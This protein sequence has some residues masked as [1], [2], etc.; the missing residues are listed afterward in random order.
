MSIV[1]QIY[2]T[3]RVIQIIIGSLLGLHS[4]NVSLVRHDSDHEGELWVRSFWLIHCSDQLI[5]D[6]NFEP[7]S[8]NRYVTPKAFRG[9][10]LSLCGL[11]VS[12]G[13]YSSCGW[14]WQSTS[15]G[16]CVAL[17]SRGLP[18]CDG[19][20]AYW[21]IHKNSTTHQRRARR[22]ARDPRAVLLSGSWL[23]HGARC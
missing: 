20:R 13:T 17:W 22:G 19:T 9:V 10:N 5:T 8:S 18:S 3:I 7:C 12:V 4:T 6:H 1:I 21:N 2:E 14:L 11:T 16:D 23:Q 15:D